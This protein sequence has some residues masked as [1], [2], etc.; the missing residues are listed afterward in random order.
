[1]SYQFYKVLHLLGIMLLFFGFGGM[2]LAAYARIDLKKPARIMGFVSHGVGLLLILVSG[3][4]MAARLGLVAGLP[5]WVQV[6]IGIW[7]LLGVAVSLVKRKGYIGWPVAILLWGLGTS[8]AI[9]AI[10]KPF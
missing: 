5:A 9:I 3:F 8:A 7:A 6:K 4:G 2:L 10:N 1:M